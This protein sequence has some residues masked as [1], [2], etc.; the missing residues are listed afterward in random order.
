MRIGFRTA[1][2]HQWP[3]PRALEALADLGY[4]AVELCLEHPDMRPETL[5]DAAAAGWARMARDLGLQIASVSYHGDRDEPPTR[6]ENQRRSI[7]LT[8]AM[9][10]DLLVLNTPR[11][12]AQPGQW[13]REMS[14][15]DESLLPEAG[16]HGARLAF[17]AE[18]GQVL[19]GLNETLRL[20]S[21]FPH[22]LLGV[23]LDIGHAWLT[24]DDLLETVRQL[25]PWLWQVHFEDFPNNEHRHLPPGHGD[26]PLADVLA[27][28]RE[29]AFG[30]V[31]VIDLFNIADDPVQW[32]QVSLETTR[33]LLQTL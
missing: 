17:E 10:C 13:A 11:R 1:G 15:I 27:A 29:A 21:A 30:G 2:F 12:N 18:P 26:M 25:A 19:D 5:T 31:L 8:A 22:P 6:K 14:W 24:D 16:A 7:N 32:A 33:E 28:L 23:N 4:D 20:L 3:L 9:D